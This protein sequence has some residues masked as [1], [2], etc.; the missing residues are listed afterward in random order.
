M[1]RKNCTAINVSSHYLSRKRHEFGTLTYILPINAALQEIGKQSI[2][3]GGVVATQ[4]FFQNF[5]ML[6]S[7]GFYTLAASQQVVPVTALIALG[8]LVITATT[9]LMWHFPVTSADP[10]TMPSN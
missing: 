2:G 5:A 6:L 1:I 10:D 8:T 7:V 3:S 4:N 9:L